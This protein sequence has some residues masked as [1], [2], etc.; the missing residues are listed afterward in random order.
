MLAKKVTTDAQTI[1][2]NL[3]AGIKD[4]DGTVR[5]RSAIELSKLP[6]TC[7][8]EDVLI[9]QLVIEPDPY[10]R[11]LMGCRLGERG[12]GRTIDSLMSHFHRERITDRNIAMAE[13]AHRLKDPQY[14]TRVIDFLL[15]QLGHPD[16]QVRRKTAV[17]FTF[18]YR[19]GETYRR[20]DAEKKLQQMQGPATGWLK[21]CVTS[22]IEKIQQA[23]AKTTPK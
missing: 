22:A 13:V 15:E 17:C 11:G 9:E 6:A 19:D 10:T 21:E 2:A 18:L 14:T 1:P 23:K 3:L 20:D 5:R 8:W 12:T 4:P 7:G 16:E